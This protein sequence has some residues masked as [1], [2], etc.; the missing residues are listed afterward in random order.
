MESHSHRLRREVL[1]SA[2]VCDSRQGTLRAKLGS[3]VLEVE[4][5]E[6]P[7]AGWPESWELRLSAMIRITMA[8][9]KLSQFRR[10]CSSR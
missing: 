4:V 10:Q 3:V 7:L 1:R 9:Q 5:A 8:A 6:W 2:E